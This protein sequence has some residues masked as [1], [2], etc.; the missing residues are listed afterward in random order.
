[1]A[2]RL[3]ARAAAIQSRTERSARSGRDRR[4]ARDAYGI[5]AS[6]V[7]PRASTHAVS[8]AAIAVKYPGEC[9]GARSRRR[10]DDRT[11]E[12]VAHDGGRDRAA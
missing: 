12:R 3:L 10:K 8:P 5:Q 7:S 4:R 6:A 11:A 9:R 2:T 1:M